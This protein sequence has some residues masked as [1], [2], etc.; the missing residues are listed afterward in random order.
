MSD[1]VFNLKRVFRAP[2]SLVWKCWT[3]EEHVAAWFS[4]PGATT[5]FLHFDCRPGGHNHYAMTTLPPEGNHDCAQGEAGTVMYG[6][7]VYR[8]VNPEDK[9]VYVNAFSD[10]EGNL[11]RH[12][13]APEWPLELLTTILFRTVEGGTE[14]DLTW[15]PLNASEQDKAV[16]AA[17]L[18]GCH[19]GWSMSLDG[20]DD[21][22]AKS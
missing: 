9:L 19:Q 2:Q 10:A 3:S 11:V 20:L 17:G 1:P 8:E 5:K 15:V 14:M 6:K 12:P 13:M 7:S 16:F 4:P 18:E 21:Y 22:L